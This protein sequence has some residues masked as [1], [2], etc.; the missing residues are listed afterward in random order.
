MII[1]TPAVTQELAF[2]RVSIE[3]KPNILV[4]Y[5]DN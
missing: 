5:K 3:K 4:V 1:A 2:L